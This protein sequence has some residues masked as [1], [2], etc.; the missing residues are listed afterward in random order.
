VSYLL[1]AISDRTGDTSAAA[2]HAA[3]AAA[4]QAETGYHPPPHLPVLTPAT[5]ESA[6]LGR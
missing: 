2:A 3:R 6:S 1:A 4:L 5:P